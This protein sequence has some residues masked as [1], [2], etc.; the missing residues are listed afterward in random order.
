MEGVMKLGETI[1]I[2]ENLELLRTLD[3]HNNATIR[4]CEPTQ[5]SQCRSSRAH[6]PQIQWIFGANALRTKL[7][8]C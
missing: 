1:K 8:V 5:L 3:S 7:R 4:Q 2:R 6:V